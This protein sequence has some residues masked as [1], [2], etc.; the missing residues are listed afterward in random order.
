MRREL[1]PLEMRRALY[2]KVAKVVMASIET[3]RPGEL[4]VHF[5][6]GIGPGG[7]TLPRQRSYQ[8]N[9]DA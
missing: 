7:W 8:L 6:V 1:L 2:E 3:G 4:A 5:P 9:K